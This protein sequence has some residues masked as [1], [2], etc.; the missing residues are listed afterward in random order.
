MRKLTLGQS[1]F[2]V[3]AALVFGLAWPRTIDA[4]RG[5]EQLV[6]IVNN[7]QLL[8]ALIAAVNAQTNAVRGRTP[9]LTPAVGQIGDALKVWP[10]TPA[11]PCAGA[12]KGDVA[13]SQT[14]ST[15]LVV[16]L[17]GQRIFVCAARVV[18]AA[19]EIPSFIEGTGTTCG[20]GT[21]PSAG[22]RRRRVAKPT[23]RTAASRAA[24]AAAA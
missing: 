7:D 9:G 1:A 17:P 11:D 3:L 23:P 18:A 13:I 16:G 6:R 2:I 5:N 4:Q 8:N 22:R 12:V 15:R 19:A 24:T 21:R 10:M 14:G 20:T